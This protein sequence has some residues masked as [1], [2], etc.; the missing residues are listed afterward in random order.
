MKSILLQES[1]YYEG[2]QSHPSGMQG[3]LRG[4]IVTGNG[5]TYALHTIVVVITIGPSLHI[6]TERLESLH[7][8]KDLHETFYGVLKIMS[9]QRSVQQCAS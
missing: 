4:R 7:R 8:G 9:Q 5:G 1:S 6:S 3:V 2:L